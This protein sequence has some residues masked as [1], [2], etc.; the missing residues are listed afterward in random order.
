M[1]AACSPRPPS[2]PPPRAPPPAHLRIP[3]YFGDVVLRGGRLSA[4]GATRSSLPRGP[5]RRR[6]A[7]SPGRRAASSRARPQERRRAA[8]PRRA[9]RGREERR[10]A[11]PTPQSRGGAWGSAAVPS[12]RHYRAGGR[13]GERRQRRARRTKAASPGE[14]GIFVDFVFCVVSTFFVCSEK[15][16]AMFWCESFTL[17]KP[18]V[19]VFV[20][21]LREFSCRKN[22]NTVCL[23]STNKFCLGQRLKHVNPLEMTSKVASVIGMTFLY[24]AGYSI[25]LL[26]PKNEAKP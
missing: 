23:G 7:S 11:T 2:A 22:K 16:L 20:A 14:A 25:V 5:Q 6:R 24:D 10:R 8:S 3:Q 17:C 12:P 1:G 15:K 4:R 18:L 13:P 9:A 19:L 21:L 26:K